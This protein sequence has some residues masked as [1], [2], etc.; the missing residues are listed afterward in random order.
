MG[1]EPSWSPMTNELFYR[2]GSQFMSVQYE[3]ESES[4]FKFHEPRV[5]CEGRLENVPGSSYRIASDGQRILVLKPVFDVTQIVDVRIVHNWITEL[6]RLV[7]SPVN[8]PLSPL[9]TNR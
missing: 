1:E 4:E 5:A 2:N 6:T 9:S 3:I 8:Q 7:P